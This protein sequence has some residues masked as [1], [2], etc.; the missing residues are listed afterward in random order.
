[1]YLFF[2]TE[3][4]GLPKKKHAS[5]HRVANWPRIVELGWV[6]T[7]TKGTVIEEAGLLVRPDGFSV[8]AE[9]T[10]IHG[11]T[12]EQATEQ[13]SAISEVLARFLL[14]LEQS[15]LICGHQVS[16][17]HRVVGAELIRAG[18]PVDQ[19]DKPRFCTM[20]ASKTLNR[21]AT[22]HSPHPLSLSA[23]YLHLFDE[24]FAGAHRALADAKA[25]AACF[26]VIRDLQN[27]EE[28]I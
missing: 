5:M 25:C 8:P 3:T 11:I 10:A 9:S 14:A 1:M 17:D 28:D 26:F 19:L 27:S 24:P 13:G 4:T 7:D 21:S 2:D 20:E 6:L 18:M 15:E 16:F 22:G 23:L 12:T